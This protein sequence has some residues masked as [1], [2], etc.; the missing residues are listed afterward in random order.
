MWNLV[1]HVEFNDVEGPLSHT[2][3]HRAFYIMSHIVCDGC[4]CIHTIDMSA[5]RAL[6]YVASV[7]PNVEQKWAV[8]VI[9][10]MKPVWV[11]KENM[12]IIGS[13]SH[14]ALYKLLKKTFVDHWVEKHGGTKVGPLETFLSVCMCECVCMTYDLDRNI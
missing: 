4:V 7:E 12:L 1:K 2:H 6:G 11:K 13:P 9:D 3:T 5:H 14:G 8:A 10:M